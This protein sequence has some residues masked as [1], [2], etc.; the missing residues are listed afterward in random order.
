MQGTDVGIDEESPGLNGQEWY[1]GNTIKPISEPF[2]GCK[3]TAVHHVL[4]LAK[5]LHDAIQL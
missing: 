4:V 3:H 2:C 5:L 1:L